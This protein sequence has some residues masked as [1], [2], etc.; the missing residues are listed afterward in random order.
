MWSLSGQGQAI[1]IM[2]G[3]GRPA[4][5][6]PAVA[7]RAPPATPATPATPAATP[8]ALD[9]QQVT[10]LHFLSYIIC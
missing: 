3:S 2:S 1:C 9:P 4:A 8:A 5:A 10:Y 7:A 6:T